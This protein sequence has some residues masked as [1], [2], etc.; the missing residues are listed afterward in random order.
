VTAH[1]ASAKAGFIVAADRICVRHLQTILAWLEKPQTGDMWQRRAAQNEG[2]Y[3][4]IA[5]TISRLQTL[6]PPPGPASGAFAGYLTTLKARAALYR[7]TGIAD[8]HRDGSTAALLQ[9]RVDQIKPIG[10]RDAHHYGLHVCGTGPGD[11]APLLD[12]APTIQV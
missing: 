3:R 9:R 4:I 8:G 12:Q 10:D 5:A 2:T 1:N 7:L 6:G 11:I